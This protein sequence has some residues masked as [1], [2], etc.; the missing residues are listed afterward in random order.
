VRRDGQ[1][2]ARP[3]DDLDRLADQT[4]GDVVFVFPIGN[5]EPGHHEQRRVHAHHDRHRTRLAAL[6]IAALDQIAMLALRAHDGRHIRPLGLHPISTVIDPAGIG[7]LHDHH[8]TGAD[9]ITA[10][11]FVPSRRRNGLDVHVLAA[12]HVLQERPGLDGN[13][14]DAARLLHVFAPIGDQLDRRA[15]DRH[16]EREVDAPH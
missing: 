13:R 7:I 15:I 6:V 3:F 2:G 14:C 11:V 8:A 12:V 10:I 16:A 4:T 9:V 5:L 1:S